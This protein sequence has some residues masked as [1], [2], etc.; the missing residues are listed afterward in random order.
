MNKKNII[1]KIGTLALGARMQKLSDTIRNDITR[2]Y[3]E[4]GVDFESKW[5]PVI[6]ILSIKKS[7]SVVELADELGYAHPSVITLVRELQNKRL[8]K[9]SSH[10]SDGRK[11]IITLTPKARAMVKKMKP[12]WKKIIKV[13]DRLT[14]NKNSLLKAIEEVEVQLIKESF[15]D[16]LQKVL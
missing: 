6:Y 3:K 2:I 4:H 9:S 15:Y 13:N 7:L 10:K 14:N 5:F 8:L 16:R 1:D 12:L 11:R